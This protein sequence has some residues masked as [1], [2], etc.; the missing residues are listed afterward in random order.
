MLE[1]DRGAKLFYVAYLDLHAQM[2]WMMRGQETDASG[3]A[4]YQRGTMNEDLPSLATAIIIQPS[5][6]IHYPLSTIHS[7]FGS[8]SFSYLAA[9]VL[10]G[11]GLLIGSFIPVS[12]PE[13]LA[14]HSA[15]LARRVSKRRRRLSAGLPA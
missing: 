15:H 9:T 2:Q 5:S 4:N 6:T 11:L 1:N 8:M 13:Q 10:L 3:G 7:F 14:E 12:G